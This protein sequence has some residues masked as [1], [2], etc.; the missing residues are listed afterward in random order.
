MR[1]MKKV[2]DR[3]TA[4]HFYEWMNFFVHESHRHEVEQAIHALLREH[5]DLIKTRSW[6]EMRNLAGV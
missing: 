2:M 5:P 1:T 4:E 6:P 3:E